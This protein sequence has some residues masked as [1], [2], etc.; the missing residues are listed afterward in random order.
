MSDIPIAAFPITFAYSNGM[1]APTLS[2]IICAKV[3]LAVGPV[4][5]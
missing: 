1:G 3:E 4:S 2:G 5:S